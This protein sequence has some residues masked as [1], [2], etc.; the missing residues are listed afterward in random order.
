LADKLVNIFIY[1]MG[2]LKVL[3]DVYRLAIK[4]L[5]EETQA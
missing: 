4:G 2:L 3:L 1:S 5:D